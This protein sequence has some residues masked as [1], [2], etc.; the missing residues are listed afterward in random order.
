MMLAPV[1][2]DGGLRETPVIWQHKTASGD[3]TCPWQSVCFAECHAQ[4]NLSDWLKNG[5]EYLSSNSQYA[6]NVKICQRVADA[7]LLS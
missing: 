1:G 5:S 2:G 3:S 7:L 6:L 4:A